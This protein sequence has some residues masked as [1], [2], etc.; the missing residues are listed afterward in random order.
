MESE[1]SLWELIQT[2]KV[3]SA[4]R[5]S[6]GAAEA[7]QLRKQDMENVN[8]VGRSVIIGF[9]KIDQPIT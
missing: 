3:R 2:P 1:L 9:N 8:V 4:Q 6:Q 5:I 7:Q